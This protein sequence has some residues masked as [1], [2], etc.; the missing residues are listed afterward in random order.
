MNTITEKPQ[1][2]TMQ[3]ATDWEESSRDR[4]IYTTA[5]ASVSQETLRR[6]EQKD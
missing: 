1:P 5:P 3:G 2:D 6:R 4:G